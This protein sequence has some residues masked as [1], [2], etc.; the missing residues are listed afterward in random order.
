[1]CFVR[2]CMKVNVFFL[3]LVFVV[4]FSGV[5]SASYEIDVPFSDEYIEVGLNAPNINVGEDVHLELELFGVGNESF[6]VSPRIEIYKGDEDV[7]VL[8]AEDVE[9]FPGDKIVINISLDTDNYSSGD[10]L[11]VAFAEYGRGS[12]GVGNPFRIGEFKVRMVNYTD[13]FAEGK[14]G[15]FE[16]FVESLWNDDMKDVYAEVNVLDFP[17]ANS[18]TSTRDLGAWRGRLF[19]GFLDMSEIVGDSFKAE[20]IL[21]YDNEVTSEIVE[22]KIDRGFDY[23][24]W[25][26]LLIVIVVIGFLI[27]RG[28]VFVRGIKKHRIKK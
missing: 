18:V 14:V 10:Y 28:L 17:A 20:I 24:F 11:A 13:S 23:V 9:V 27:W 25:I 16:I 12:L 1:M 2:F 6:V 5:S 15:R 22:L 21:H 19:V 8:T 3:V 26:M 4:L 7:E